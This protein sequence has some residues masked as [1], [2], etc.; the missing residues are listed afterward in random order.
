MDGGKSKTFQAVSGQFRILEE[1]NGNFRGDFYFKAKN[2][3]NPSDSVMIT[4][5]YFDIFLEN[6]DRVFP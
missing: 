5:G 1:N 2:I 4:D 3:V 6:H